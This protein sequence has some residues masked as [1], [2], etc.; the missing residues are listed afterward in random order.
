MSSRSS[1]AAG[2]ISLSAV[3]GD[4]IPVNMMVSPSSPPSKVSDEGRP[5]GY[6]LVVR[7]GGRIRWDLCGPATV[8]Y[9]QDGSLLFLA[10][11]SVLLECHL[12]YAGLA[13]AP[14]AIWTSNG[15]G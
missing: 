7:V 14:A 11:G 9:E 15:F 12:E 5:D 4:P 1:T 3:L 8:R 10:R 13:V 2:V 6:V